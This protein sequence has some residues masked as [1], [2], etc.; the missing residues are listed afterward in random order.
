MT[1]CDQNTEGSDYPGD[2]ILKKMSKMMA[3]WILNFFVFTNCCSQSESTSLNSVILNNDI[4]EAV[5]ILL[6]MKN[7]DVSEE[8]AL[9]P[10]PYNL[11][12]HMMRKADNVLEIKTKKKLFKSI[13]G[14]APTDFEAYLALLDGIDK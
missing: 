9:E 12:K 2:K 6:R 11:M 7:S 10:S 13:S 8:D 1:P 4:I 5:D 3:F 14:Q